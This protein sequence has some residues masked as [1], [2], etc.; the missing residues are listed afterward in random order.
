MRREEKLSNPLKQK[1]EE[2]NHRL[3]SLKE[4]LDKLNQEARGWAEKRNSIQKQI[5]TLRT[6]V[7]NLKEK[8][9]ELNESVREL[10]NMREQAIAERREKHTQILKLNEKLKCLKEKKPLRNMSNVESEIEK[11]EWKIQTTS[12]PVREERMLIDQVR[13][14]ETQLLTHKKLRELEDSLLE[15][16][17]EEK[18][19]ETKAKLH[20]ERL[21]ELAAQSQGFHEKMTET[22]GEIQAL[23]AEADD[24]HKK[25]VEIKQQA[26]PFRQER[27]E[28]LRQAKRLK[29]EL[30]QLE[31]EKQLKRQRELHK[32]L[33]EKALEKLR[34]GE[35]LSWEEFKVLSE[36][37]KIESLKTT[38]KK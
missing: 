11:L 30:R 27:G 26:Q 38:R 14:L 36:Q 3:A 33:V 37:K 2:L 22:L 7:A 17:A 23:R 15:L 5:K 18:A 34:R 10:K 9:D 35:K 16:R 32:E 6:K 19:L 13:V 25:Y 1:I 12:L 20:H 24:A 28:L 29:Q 8:R 31:E 4:E 21:S